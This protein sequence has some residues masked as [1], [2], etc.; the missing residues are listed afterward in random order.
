MTQER[1]D[2]HFQMLAALPLI[3]TL[4][5]S[6]DDSLLI[7]A[8]RWWPESLSMADK[9]LTALPTSHDESDGYRDTA[10]ED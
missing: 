2:I 8:D 1:V 9:S 6:P 3:P 4:H 5:P 7:E 10:K